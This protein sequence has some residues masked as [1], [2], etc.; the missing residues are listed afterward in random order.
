ARTIAGGADRAAS[1][2]SSR[3]EPGASVFPWPRSAA[4]GCLVAL[5]GCGGLLCGRRSLG[6][7]ARPR[8]SA[9][10]LFPPS[11]PCVRLLLAPPAPRLLAAPGFL[12]HGGPGAALRLVLAGPAR[13]VAL[14]D[15]FGLA[16]LLV[17]VLRLVSLRHDDPLACSIT[18]SNPLCGWGALAQ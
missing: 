15:M 3:R 11:A 14:F 7:R 12:V 13:L 5:A 16:L 9:P 18:R 10:L 17:R 8:R 1:G 2:S 6:S 4:L